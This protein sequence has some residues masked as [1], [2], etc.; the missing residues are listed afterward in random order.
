MACPR[1]NN[2][3]YTIGDKCSKCSYQNNAYA[4]FSDTHEG[5][6]HAIEMEIFAE[7]FFHANNIQSSGETS[8]MNMTD[9]L[10]CPN[11]RKPVHTYQQICPHCR[12]SLNFSSS[13]IKTNPPN[14][15]TWFDGLGLF[16]YGSFVLFIFY[17]VFIVI[18][19][20]LPSTELFT[21]NG[22]GMI[23]AVLLS[24]IFIAFIYFTISGVKLGGFR[25][26]NFG[27]F[28]LVLFFIFVP[29]FSFILLYYFGKGLY[30]FRKDKL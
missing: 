14:H 11:C 12:K 6:R 24:S 7:Q 27:D 21:K 5:L 20:F 3:N 13:K 25:I 1:C 28:L 9:K 10:L 2:K 26:R 29:P 18:M 30:Y 8:K 16:L 15:I 17:I 19:L 4:Q 22:M 23:S